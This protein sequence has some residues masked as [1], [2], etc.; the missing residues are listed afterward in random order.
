MVP[1]TMDRWTLFKE[2]SKVVSDL[3]YYNNVYIVALGESLNKVEKHHFDGKS[4]VFCINESVLKIDSLGIS[5]PIFS[6]HFDVYYPKLMT[7]KSKQVIAPM[8]IEH[9]HPYD[10][11]CYYTIDYLPGPTL[12][13]CITMAKKYFNFKIFRFIG[14][15]YYAFNNPT[16]AGIKYI[17]P[18]EP[19]KILVKQK[20]RMHEEVKNLH[21]LWF[22]GKDFVTKNPES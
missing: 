19:E 18:N 14:C 7:P 13:Y 11:D 20:T 17:K 12:I 1:Y 10:L 22:N 16:Y 2:G 4:P 15:D 9:L 8:G 6:I 5:N 3:N 21:A